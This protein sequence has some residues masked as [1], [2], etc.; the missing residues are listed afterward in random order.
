MENTKE[1]IR[2]EQELA[3]E[4]NII[5]R[6]TAQMCLAAAIEIGRL[7]C[8]A[9]EQVAY[10]EWG[11]WL[12]NN[13]AYSQSQANNLM[14]LY[15]NYGEQEQL[16]FFEENRM[17]IFGSL[18]PSQAVA[19]LGLPADQRREFVETHDMEQTSVRN[20][21]QEIRARKQAEEKLAEAE[22]KAENATRLAEEERERA[23]QAVSRLEEER[24]RAD[25]AVSRLEEEREN[26]RRELEQLKATSEPVEVKA[27]VEP[28]PA[29]MRAAEKE[30]KDKLQKQFDK[31]LEKEKAA[32]QKQVDEAKKSAADAAQEKAAAEQ[33]IRQEMETAYG[34]QLA[35][36]RREKESVEAKLA[37]AGN[38][39]VQKFSLHFENL[40]REFDALME[41]LQA[42]RQ[43]DA[44][45]AEKLAKAMAN[46]T[47]GMRAEFEGSGEE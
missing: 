21:E 25:E 20:I 13:V 17:D 23:E 24:E 14:R 37:N 4:I 5:K 30:L 28:D 9:K 6:R 39:A 8:E 1:I 26:L 46:I 31:K 40:Q 3:A 32:L 19:L 33:R 2:S 18:S 16:D 45:T 34:E 36:L 22:E 10:G 35:Q 41:L 12:E 15:Q 29:A 43:D 47:E 42:I 27:T 38:V 7:L 44:A 11:E